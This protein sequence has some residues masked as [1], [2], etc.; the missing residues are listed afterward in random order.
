MIRERIFK[1]FSFECKLFLIESNDV[2]ESN[3][4]INKCYENSESVTHNV[5]AVQELHISSQFAQH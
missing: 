1:D 3:S 2:S 5:R 4:K